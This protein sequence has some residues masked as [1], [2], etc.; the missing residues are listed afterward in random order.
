MENGIPREI[1]NVDETEKREHERRCYKCSSE[2]E[3]C[4]EG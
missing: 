4:I 2:N 1:N 3:R